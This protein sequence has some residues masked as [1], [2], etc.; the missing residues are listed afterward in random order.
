MNRRHIGAEAVECVERLRLAGYDNIS[1]D[2]IF[3]VADFGDEWLE[4]TLSQAIALGVEHISAYHLTVEERTRLGV[5]ARRG[6]YI[7]VD[8]ERSEME[9]LMVE[10]MLQEAGYEHYEVSNYAREGCRR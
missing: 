9:Y 7:P 6:E 5:M 8:E 1:I 10:R 2:I 4:K 3:G